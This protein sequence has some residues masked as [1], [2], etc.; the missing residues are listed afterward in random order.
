MVVMQNDITSMGLTIQ[1][2][3]S[4]LN[5]LE[6]IVNNLQNDMVVVQSNITGLSL[7]VQQH[8]DAINQI[9]DTLNTLTSQINDIVNSSKPIAGFTFNSIG[10]TDFHGNNGTGSFHG[11]WYK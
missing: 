10:F 1:Q 9:N 3:T 11:A 2:H 6:S 4:R 8:T 7:T 5:N